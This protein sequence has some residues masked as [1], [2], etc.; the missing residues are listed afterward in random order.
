MSMLTAATRMY[1]T[2]SFKPFTFLP[3][4][5]ARTPDLTGTVTPGLYVHIPFCRSICD[6]CPYCKMVFDRARYESYI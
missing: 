3:D 2:R 4:D 5:G 1:L 6:F